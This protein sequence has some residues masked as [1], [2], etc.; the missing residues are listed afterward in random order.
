M[1]GDQLPGY[2]PRASS[3]QASHGTTVRNARSEYT[4]SR[5]DHKGRK[6]L[7]LS[8]KS[9]AP[10]PDFLPLFYGG[11]LIS[12]NVTLDIL[13]PES[14]KSITAKASRSLFLSLLFPYGPYR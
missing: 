8:V 10:T 7:L 2:T 5:E 1:E 4:I 14:F 9:S 12:G 6:W 11:D 3:S 13:K